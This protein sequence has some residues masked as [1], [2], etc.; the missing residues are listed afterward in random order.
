MAR[1]IPL[2]NIKQPLYRPG[3]VLRVPGGWGSHISRQSANKGDKVSRKLSRP[4]G[5]SAAGRIVSVKISN[6]T[7][8]NR[9]R[10]LL[11]YSAV[12]QPTAPPRVGRLNRD[13]EWIAN[14]AE[15]SSSGLLYGS[16]PVFACSALRLQTR[17]AGQDL[18][19]WAPEHKSEVRTTLPR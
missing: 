13:G 7:I 4:Q 6:D 5:H 14:S 9:T 12:P 16:T 11:A 3:Q 15:G 10:D 1:K 18:N 8:G 19:P 2:K 17:S